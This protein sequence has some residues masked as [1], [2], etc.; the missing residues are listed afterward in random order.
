MSQQ[1]YYAKGGQRLGPVPAEQLKELAASGELLPADLIWRKG[2]PQWVQAATVQ[3]LFLTASSVRPSTCPPPV[4]I[5]MPNPGEK[6]SPPPKQS[7]APLGKAAGGIAT[8]LIG[9]AIFCGRTYLRQHPHS[10]TYMRPAASQSVNPSQQIK[11]LQTN[12]Q[13]A[14]YKEFV[15]GLQSVV[16]HGTEIEGAEQIIRSKVEANESY[17]DALESLIVANQAT[18]KDVDGL[19]AYCDRLLVG[20]LTV[21][22]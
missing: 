6:T 5:N 19:A 3:G 20:N 22:K 4:P 15:D 11:R 13:L 14:S 10:P 9:M 7:S 17:K 21:E 18:K 12:E 16:A 8:L 2:M 1:W